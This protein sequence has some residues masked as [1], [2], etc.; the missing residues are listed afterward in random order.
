MEQM[1]V[2]IETLTHSVNS[3]VILEMKKG[4]IVFASLIYVQADRQSGKGFRESVNYD[5]YLCFLF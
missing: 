2:K 1:Y 3:R 5:L 4:L